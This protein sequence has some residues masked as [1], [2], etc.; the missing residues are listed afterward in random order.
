[1]FS[2]TGEQVEKGRRALRVGGLEEAPLACSP[3]CCPDSQ[4]FRFLAIVIG[5]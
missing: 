1:L 2:P 4:I 5:R 3:A